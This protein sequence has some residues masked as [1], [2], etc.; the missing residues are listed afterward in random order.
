[1]GGGIV[2]PKFIGRFGNQLHQYCSARAWAKFHAA[3]F[4]C[5]E[6]IGSKVFDLHD[7]LPSV[8]LPEVNDGGNGLEPSVREGQVNVRIGGYFMMQRW[9]RLFDRTELQLHL[10]VRPEWLELIGRE[11]GIWDQ[12]YVAA[13]VRR[14]DYVGHWAYA[15]VSE[16]SYIN[17][18][19][20]FGLP[21]DRVVWVREDAPLI[22]PGIPD[23]ISF[24]PDFV[25]LMRARVLLR[26]NSSFSWWAAVLGNA[27]EVFAPVVEDRVGLVDV[28]FVRGNW[29]RVADTSRVGIKCE[30][31]HVPE[32]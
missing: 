29:P 19:V 23:E 21:E 24:L 22:V 8:E 9:A 6:W 5:P 10:R 15:E 1:M 3:R 13:H 11:R 17:A 26:A 4:E 20:E 18:L 32:C 2:Q 7:P 28:P 27:E 16:R 14:G 12:W 31:L 25:R 30:D